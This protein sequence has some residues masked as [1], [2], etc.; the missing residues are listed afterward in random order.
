[1]EY[2]KTRPGNH[3]NSKSGCPYCGNEKTQEQRYQNKE[4]ILYYIYLPEYN[5]YKIGLT[6]TSVQKRIKS[7]T[8][9]RNH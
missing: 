5:L 3:L 7:R 6:Q 1:M 2:G 9:N 8:K 4:T